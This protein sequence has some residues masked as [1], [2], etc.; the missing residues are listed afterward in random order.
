[1][2]IHHPLYWGVVAGDEV[3]QSLGHLIP[4][5]FGQGPGGASGCTVQKCLCLLHSLHASSC[6][7]K[8]SPYM[9]ITL[10]FFYFHFY[11]SQSQALRA[12]LQ[13][14]CVL[15]QLCLWLLLIKTL[16]PFFPRA[17]LSSHVFLCSHCHCQMG[18]AVFLAQ[19]SLVSP[20]CG[21]PHQKRHF[22]EVVGLQLRIER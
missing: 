19:D 18:Q 22:R 1:M 21:W 10:Q 5:F 13:L 12:A 3:L 7:L 6:H 14:P 11:R 16:C 2:V 15:L 8:G 9:T 20:E 17:P 4:L